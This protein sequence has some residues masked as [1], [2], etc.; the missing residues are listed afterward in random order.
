VLSNRVR[1]AAVLGCGTPVIAVAPTLVGRLEAEELDRV[2]VHE[3]GHVQRRD[4]LANLAQ[5]LVRAI[6][7]WHP[8]AWWLDRRLSIEQ[9]LACDEIVVAVSGGARSYA[10]SLVKLASLRCAQ[11]DTLLASGALSSAGLARRVTRLIT[12]K[13]VTGSL[14][15]RAAAALGVLLLVVLTLGIAP[16]RIVEAA[17]TATVAR[18]AQPAVSAAV[19]ATTTGGAVHSA[20]DARRARPG[21]PNVPSI[22]TAELPIPTTGADRAAEPPAAPGSA[23]TIVVEP[24]SRSASA[25][26]ES[27]RDA[28]PA[29]APLDI[30]AVPTLISSPPQVETDSPSAWSPVADAGVAVARGSRKAGVVTAGAFTRFAKQIAGSF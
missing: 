6:A 18:V 22:P 10:S 15:S 30:A 12:P 17:V 19:D 26:G 5:L 8:A 28:D 1:A 24:T 7:G 3:W 11:H 13:K 14:S 23:D 16:V 25:D 4:D 20:T 29:S 27:V 2:I 9:E 21:Q